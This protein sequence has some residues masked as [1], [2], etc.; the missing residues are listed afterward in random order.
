MVIFTS[1]ARPAGVKHIDIMIAVHLA[2]R[3]GILLMSRPFEFLSIVVP[4]QELHP[5]ICIGGFWYLDP[6]LWN[7]SD[8]MDEAPYDYYWFVKPD[9]SFMI[10]TD[11][12]FGR[13]FLPT[14]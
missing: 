4:G 5:V 2:C 8:S 6:C 1:D 13:F 7:S 3:Y 9:I 12:E 14:T 11:Y 10:S